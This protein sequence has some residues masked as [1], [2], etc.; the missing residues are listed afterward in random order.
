MGREGYGPQ[1]G[2]AQQGFGYGP[3]VPSTP[4]GQ[5]LAGWWK[6]VAA[7]IIDSII[8]FVIGLPVTGYFVYRYIQA[9]N[10]SDLFATPA[11]GATPSFE[12]PVEI[13]QWVIPASILGL[14]VE[15]AYSYFFLTRSGATPGKKAMGLSVRLR[16]V[17]GPPPGS[18]VLKRWASTSVFG[19]ICGCL[20]LIDV[21]FPLWDSQKQAL[22]DKIADTNVVVGP[23][24]RR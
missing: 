24:Q 19:F 18:T 15:L 5:E 14:L 2:H 10:D 12:L 13:Y 6:R 1:G 3:G 8:V 23:Q 21:L 22:H 17:P 11:A 9:I 16:A 7:R 4:D 20:S